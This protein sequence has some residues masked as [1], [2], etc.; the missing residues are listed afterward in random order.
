MQEDFILSLKKYLNDEILCFQNRMW[1]KNRNT[2]HFTSCAA[3]NVADDLSNGVDLNRNFGF[4]WNS[5]HNNF[6]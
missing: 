2:E 1:R 3:T 4:F 6:F 5:K